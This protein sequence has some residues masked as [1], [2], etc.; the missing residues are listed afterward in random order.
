MTNLIIL[1]III[2]AAAGATGM[3]L[4]LVLYL[5]GSKKHQR[6]AVCDYVVC[7]NRSELVHLIRFINDRKYTVFSTGQLGEHLLVFF[8]RP[9]D[10]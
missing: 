10:G 8:W 3:L 9:A 6:K 1:T 2:S 4:A 7:S 5:T